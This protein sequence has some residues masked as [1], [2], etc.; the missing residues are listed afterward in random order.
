MADIDK[1]KAEA[2]AAVKAVEDAV[3]AQAATAAAQ[4]EPRA[5]GNILHDLLFAIAEKLGNEPKIEALV[6][7][8]HAATAPKE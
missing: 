7:E 8:Y 4:G 6:K 5:A 2:E 3:R 1:L